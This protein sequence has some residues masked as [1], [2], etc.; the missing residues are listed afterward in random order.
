[1]NELLLRRRIM[2]MMS[3]ESLAS[4]P[5]GYVTDGLIF[6]LDGA[7]KG[8]DNTKWSDI[9]GGKTFKLTDCTFVAKGVEFNGSTSE[10]EFDGAI[11]H[12]YLNETI[13][14]VGYSN[15]WKSK[16]VL[17]QTKGDGDIGI[18]AAVGSSLAVTMRLDGVA[19]AMWRVSATNAVR[20][21]G[22]EDYC[23]RNGTQITST[24]P[25][26]FNYT[27]TGKTW[28]G[29]RPTGALRMDGTIY[30]IRIYNRKL[31]VAEMQQNQ[32]VDLQRYLS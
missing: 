23:V 30:A 24:A 12:N 29:R 26:Y 7:Q 13:E 21:S 19:G 28:L 32:A 10:G 22:N 27:E 5:E 25:N 14:F 16:A 31:S 6:F 1:M 2:Q 15:D 11:S 3:E 8:V 4:V 18:G 17:W 20:Y 9:V